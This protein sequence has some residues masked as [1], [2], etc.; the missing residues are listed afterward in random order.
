IALLLF[1]GL[2]TAI[3]LTTTTFALLFAALPVSALFTS[4]GGD[5][6]IAWPVDALVWFVAAWWVAKQSGGRPDARRGFARALVGVVGAA[7]V[8]GFLMSL[9]VE[10]TGTF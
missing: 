8:Y 7:L 3:G 10:P 2:L 1:A 6:V 9:L 4:F 5:F